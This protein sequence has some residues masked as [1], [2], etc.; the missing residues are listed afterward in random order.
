M[1]QFVIEKIEELRSGTPQGASELKAELER[2][3][4]RIEAA[5]SHYE[6]GKRW[7]DMCHKQVFPERKH[8]HECPIS[9][10]RTHADLAF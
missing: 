8:A 2:A 7:C 6:D 4:T 9:I 5:C 10:T 1:S 3:W